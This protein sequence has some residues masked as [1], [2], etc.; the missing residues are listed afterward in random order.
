MP[1]VFI[2]STNRDLAD[3]RLAA[4]MA[5]HAA[6][7]TADLQ[8]NWT[9]EDHPPL[10]SCLERV[11]QTDVLVVILAHRYGWVPEDA[12]R[13]PEGKSITW[14]ECEE[15][16]GKK[17]ILAFVVD[18]GAD[19]PR[20]LRKDVEL[21][22][23]GQLTDRT[24]AFSLMEAT[25][26][27]INRLKDFKQWIGVRG[28]R[29]TFCTKEEFKLEVE[30]ALRTWKARRATE[31]RRLAGIEESGQFAHIFVSYSTEDRAWTK[32]PIDALESENFNVW[33][34]QNL[35]AGLRFDKAIENE[36]LQARCVI[37][38]W[39]QNSVNSDWVRSEATWAEK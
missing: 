13:N 39:S 36:L 8:E 7:L 3:Y 35:R 4:G 21:I 29:R 28:L 19:W 12:A 24:Q 6:E 11:R 23:A 20:E 15:A 34:D 37:V 26:Q 10:E 5:A 30:R 14:L 2:S 31:S 33:W 22:R 17:D 32:K 25:W 16:A 1:R 38:V 9:A 27:R 18:E